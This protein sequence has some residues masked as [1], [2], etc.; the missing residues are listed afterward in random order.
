MTYVSIAKRPT[1][2]YTLLGRIL[3]SDYSSYVGTISEEDVGTSVTAA[4]E[5]QLE[6]IQRWY[7]IDQPQKVLAY[8]RDM[9]SIAS[10]LLDARSVLEQYFLATPKAVELR[11]DT[12][13]ETGRSEL[14]AYIRT[15]MPV[16]EAV[17]RLREFDYNWLMSLPKEIIEK[18]DFDV[19]FV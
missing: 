15:S 18:L 19:V 6:A 7:D 17:R 2:L 12:D 11:I 13:P 3:P 5:V 9:P 14:V 4:Q 10:V 1:S 16:E 8:L